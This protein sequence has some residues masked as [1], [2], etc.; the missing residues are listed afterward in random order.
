MCTL[1]VMVDDDMMSDILAGHFALLYFY[2][3]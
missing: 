3:L 2:E 1:Y